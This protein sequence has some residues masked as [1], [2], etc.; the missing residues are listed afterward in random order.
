[1]EKSK[2]QRENSPY[3][4]SYVGQVRLCMWREFQ[5]LKKDPRLVLLVPQNVPSALT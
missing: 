2:N 5:R 4:L 1:M 3:T